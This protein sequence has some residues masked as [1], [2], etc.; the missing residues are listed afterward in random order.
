MPV[1]VHYHPFSGETSVNVQHSHTYKGI[2][3]PNIPKGLGHVHE[4]AAATSFDYGHKHDLKTVTG[5]AI[6]VRG[7]GHVHRYSGKTT[8]NGRPP[9]D[10]KYSGATSGPVLS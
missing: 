6:P 10:H 7:G 4:M 8:V 9:H 2:T 3:G 1:N 5:P